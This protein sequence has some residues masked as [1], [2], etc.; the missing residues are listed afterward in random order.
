MKVLAAD[1]PA[2]AAEA[3]RLHIRSSMENALRRLEPFFQLQKVHPQTYSRTPK[4]RIPLEALLA[5]S[6]V[7]GNAAAL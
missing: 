1:D 2:A 5:P 3:M 6:P 4:K 7:S